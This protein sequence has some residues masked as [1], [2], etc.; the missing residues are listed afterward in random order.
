[1]GPALKEKAEPEYAIDAL[2]KAIGGRV[3]AYEIFY[4]EDEGVTV[5][6]KE[7]TI[8]SFKV[9]S[10]SGIGLRIISGNRLGFGFSSALSV[11]A[12]KR[13]ADNTIAASVEAS[14][15]GFLGLPGKGA[16]PD[17]PQDLGI[18]D[19]A[20]YDAPKQRLLKTAL[21]I[22][23]AARAKDPRIKRVRKAMYQESRV[24]SRVV[25]SSG[26]DAKSSATF[27]SGSVTAVAEH[28]A[29]SQM[30]WD[31]E[32]AHLRDGITPG[33]VGQRAASNALR[34]LGAR[35]IKTTRCPA[36]IENTVAIELVEALSSSFLFDN[37]SKG[38]SMLAEKIGAAVAS[39]ALNIWDD[40]ILKGGWATSC[41]DGEGLPR[42]KTELLSKGVLKGYL[43]DAYWA[44]RGGKASTGNAVRSGYR[45]V[46]SVG[47]TNLYIEKGALSLEEMLKAMGQ[48]LMVTELLGVHTI[49]TVSGDFSLGAQG[50]W[51]EGGVAAYPVRGIAI[52]GNLLELFKRVRCCGTD[53]RFMGSVGSPS[54]LIEEIDASGD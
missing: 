8:D 51:V 15:D 36:V 2:K 49:N 20:F 22:E 44:R 26:I 23:D 48:G 37:V 46:P 28:G 16:E 1:M 21:E 53:A 25:N 14:E 10:G 13:L 42:K 9:R 41:H 12:L 32:T 43:Y 52:A 31:M 6:A 17:L 47:T 54:L 34:M 39:E 7:K 5:E 4:S 40:G 11:D 30:G 35:K 33:D 50:L 19:G 38:K 29:E 18:Y 45:G 3:T 27:F 24:F